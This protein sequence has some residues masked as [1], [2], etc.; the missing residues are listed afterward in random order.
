MNTQIF[1]A[2]YNLAHT[3]LAFDMSIVF[4]TGPVSYVIGP[5]LFFTYLL[6]VAK[7]KMYWFSLTFLTLITSW[8][9]AH[10]IKLLV[11]A[12]RP[13]EKLSNIIPLTHPNNYS[14]PS[15]HAT[16]YAAL[17]VIAFS[18]DWHFGLVVC[19][20]ALCIGVSRVIAGVHF[21][22]DIL[23]GFIVGTL[24][25]YAFVIFFKKYL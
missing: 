15:E 1:Y 24:V 19:I 3:S 11:H 23:A 8:L 25:A 12:P 9:I 10:T 7:E 18:F 16:V 4:L 2:L 13:F 5:L 20:I 17:T 21:P 14:F 22:I 6:I